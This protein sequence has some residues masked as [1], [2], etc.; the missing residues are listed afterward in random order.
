MARQVSTGVKLAIGGGVAAVALLLGLSM[1]RG[2]DLPPIQDKVVKVVQAKPEA[3]PAEPVE[4]TRAQPVAVDP[5]AL[6]VKRVLPID[7]PFRH[8]DYVWDEGGAPAKGPL[9]VTV[10]LKA[11]T[12]SVF[13]AGYEIGSAV[14]L[15][16]ADDKPSPLGA[17]PIIQK[18]ADHYS[19]T[20]NNAPMPYT[21]R[22]TSD[23]VA[24]HGSD[25]QW[26]N[27]THGCIGV[28]K[29]FAKKLFGVAKLGDL[30]V[31]TNGRMLDTSQA[32]R[33]KA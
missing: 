22:L 28:P 8:G 13:R 23:G 17:F 20:Y 27:A 29:A 31:I 19:S 21:L 18:D 26:G 2:S 5:H 11:Q 4:R 16:G 1:G 9:I 10:D 15:Y 30:V 33:D 14:I 7:G 12:L 6:M 32:S 3:K 24:I 25:V